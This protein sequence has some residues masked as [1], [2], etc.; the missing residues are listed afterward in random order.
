MNSAERREVWENAWAKA[1]GP[2]PE[3]YQ[4]GEYE[5][6]CALRDGLYEKYLPGIAEVSEFGAGLGHNLVPLL[7]TGRRLRA[8]DWSE[9]AVTRCHAQGFEAHTFDML[10]PGNFEISG[11][12]LTVHAMEQ[13]G[14][15]FIPFVAFLHANKPLLCIHIEPIEELYDD[16]EHDQLCL[17]YHK[18]RG[19]LSGFLTCLR[20]MAEGGHAEI[21]EVRKSEIHGVNHDAYSVVVW[22]PL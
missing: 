14:A 12:A 20:G 21:L 16:S 1:E 3:Y 17:A 13:L 8:F 5:Q 19:Y 10:H 15:D 18:K 7:R 9:E 2:V 6:F 4:T 11:C 22:R